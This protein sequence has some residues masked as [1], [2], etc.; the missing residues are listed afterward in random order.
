MQS[1][2]VSSLQSIHYNWLLSVV[3]APLLKNIFLPYATCPSDFT[4]VTLPNPQNIKLS[5]ALNKVAI[6]RDFG[7]PHLS[8]PFC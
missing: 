8:A 6:T 7:S 1:V 3:Y 4:H 2:G 5:D